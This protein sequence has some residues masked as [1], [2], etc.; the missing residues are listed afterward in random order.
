[1]R[2]KKTFRLLIPAGIV[3]TAEHDHSGNEGYSEGGG[4]SGLD[5]K[6]FKIQR[7]RIRVEGRGS[8]FNWRESEHSCH[9]LRRAPIRSGS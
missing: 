1:M 7:V 8:S 6:S 9:W 5:R 4:V 3:V 2:P